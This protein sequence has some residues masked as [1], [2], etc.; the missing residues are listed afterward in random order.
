MRPSVISSALRGTQC[1]RPAWLSVSSL[2]SLPAPCTT[3]RRHRHGQRAGLHLLASQS[4]HHTL[5]QPCSLPPNPRPVALGPR[6][7]SPQC[8]L[9][10]R[11]RRGPTALHLARAAPQRLSCTARAK[12]NTVGPASTQTLGLTKRSVARMPP[13]AAGF[14]TSAALSACQ[15]TRLA[16]PAHGFRVAVATRDP[17]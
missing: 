2:G 5:L 4:R 17:K 1:S 3:L 7:H 13:T 12:R 10:L 6:C 16:V 8:G 15:G 9:T 11:S 14:K